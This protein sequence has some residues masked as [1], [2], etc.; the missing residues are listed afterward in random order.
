M[1]SWDGWSWN[2]LAAG[3]VGGLIQIRPLWAW[4][5]A[6]GWEAYEG[7]MRRLWPGDGIFAP[8]SWPNVIGDILA[9]MVAFHVVHPLV[10]RVRV[11]LGEPRHK[12]EESP[13]DWWS[14]THIG[15]GI[16][17]G[18]AGLA[19]FWAGLVLAAVEVGQAVLRRKP[20][21]WLRLGPESWHNS[22]A[23]VAV[24]LAGCTMVWLSWKSHLPIL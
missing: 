22:V 19:L 1:T 13:L 3:A 9:A 4:L 17:L 16:L 2:H 21:K 20:L 11:R 24:G 23:D 14:L 10:R 15:S 18:V 7:L 6:T 12:I 8:E 5:L